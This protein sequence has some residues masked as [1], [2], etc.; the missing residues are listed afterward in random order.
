MTD[1]TPDF[2]ELCAELLQPLA[3]YNDTDPFHEHSFL[4]GRA[5]A[6]LATPPPKPPTVMQILELSE[7]IEDAGLGQIDLVRAVLKR[8]GAK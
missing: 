7:E 2:R 1:P 5:R 6:A 8:W 4:F 3:E